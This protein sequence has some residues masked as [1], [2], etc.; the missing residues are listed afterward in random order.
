MRVLNALRSVIVK[1]VGGGGG[2]MGGDMVHVTVSP[3]STRFT[4]HLIRLPTSPFPLFPPILTRPTKSYLPFPLAAVL[5]APVLRFYPSPLMQ[6]TIS[7][8]SLSLPI[9]Q[10][11]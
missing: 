4:Q 10:L 9:Y 6:F 3:V 5:L 11:H 7:P 1:W 8:R 2:K